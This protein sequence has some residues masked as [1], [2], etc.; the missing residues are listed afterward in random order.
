MLGFES[1]ESKFARDQVASDRESRLI[2]ND[3]RVAEAMFDP[4]KVA[5]DSQ[6]SA[7]IL[8]VNASFLKYKI[9]YKNGTK[10]CLEHYPFIEPW[11]DEPVSFLEG[12]KPNIIG[13]IDM[14]LSEM[15]KYT[16]TYEE[17]TYRT[18]NEVVRIRQSLLGLSRATG[19]AAKVAKSQYVESNA[20]IRRDNFGSKQQQ[21][22][23]L[24]L[25]IM[26][27]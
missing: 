27:L 23:L 6:V 1:N 12:Q 4:N 13:E 18:F 8:Q 20:N 15:Y 14:L 17:P 9:D 22:G 3:S 10:I 24:G 5:L 7:L 25:G 19:R 16:E 11:G 26:G 21:K 2:D